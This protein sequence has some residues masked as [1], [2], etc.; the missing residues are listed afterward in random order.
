MKLCPRSTSGGI[1]ARKPEADQNGQKHHQMESRRQTVQL[2]PLHWLTNEQETHGGDPSSQTPGSVRRLL[3]D[4]APRESPTPL[5]RPP[6]RT[7]L[8]PLYPRPPAPFPASCDQH[9]TH[10]TAPRRKIDVRYGRTETQSRSS[11]HRPLGNH[12]PRTDAHSPPLWAET[13]RHASAA[14]KPGE[15]QDS[16]QGVGRSPGARI[17]QD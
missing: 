8:P 7:S 2:L 5:T 12:P 6:L 14:G 17:S 11:G 15:R 10:C 16:Q 4:D 13:I 3:L 1:Y 9:S